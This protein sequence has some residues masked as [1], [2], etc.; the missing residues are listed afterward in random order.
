MGLSETRVLIIEDNVY[1]AI[2]IKRAL[3]M[4]G[5]RDILK[6]N[7]QEEAWKI[8]YNSMNQEK[9]ISLIVTDM[10]YPLASGGI[11]DEEAGFK[12]IERLKEEGIK[13][14]VIVCSSYKYNISE[15]LG[16]VWYSNLR[17][18]DLDFKELLEGWD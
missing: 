15:I 13:I 10:H 7:N 14:P 6:V 3:S 4:S 12:L 1:K 8:I 9:E 17:D 16:S 5:I 11:A 2:D 18:L